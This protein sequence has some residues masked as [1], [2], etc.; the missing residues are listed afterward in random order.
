MTTRPQPAS[1]MSPMAS[2]MQWNVPARFTSI[3]CWKASGEMSSK[4][5]NPEIAALV[6]MIS[7]GPSSV[8][9]RSSAVDTADRSDTSTPSP[10]AS[11]PS[12]NEAA[13]SAAAS[14]WR[15]SAATAAPVAARC[16]QTARPTPDAPPVTTATRL[17]IGATPHTGPLPVRVYSILVS[18]GWRCKGLRIRRTRLSSLPSLMRLLRIGIAPYRGVLAAVVVFQ[19]IQTA[20]VLT[21]PTLNSQIIDQPGR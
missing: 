8:R 17:D 18:R 11:T 19:A 16:A 12:G 20:A 21:L 1:T 4:G 5:V 2:W 6:T 7:I 9:T 10:K 3:I 13:T 14:P 15:S